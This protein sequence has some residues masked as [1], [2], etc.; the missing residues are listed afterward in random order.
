MIK[1]VALILTILLTFSACKNNYEYVEIVETREGK[2]AKNIKTIHALNDSTAYIE[3]FTRFCISVKHAHDFNYSEKPVYFK[4]YNNK[5]VDISD[6]KFSTKNSIEIG[7]LK[8][9][10]DLYTPTTGDE[11]ETD[12]RPID[13]VKVKKMEKSFNIKLDEFS[14][15]NTKWY[16]TK[17]APKYSNANGIYCY[18][19]TENG[20]PGNFRFRVQY[21]DDD[22]LFFTHIQF[23]IDGK[24]Y[25]YV[26]NST[27]TDSGNGGYIWEWFDESVKNSDK[28]LINALANAKSAK[29]KFV[30]RK[31]YDVKTITSGQ[32]K[33]INETIELYKALGGKF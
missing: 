12:V 26:P 22:W 31:Y 6:I 11:P 30:G 3:A 25:E 14:N 15:D 18:F 29:I 33:A 8:S 21:Y 7:I 32:I 28:E 5:R 23:S 20:V 24:A 19:Q 17:S 10:T 4:L 13:T 2:S 27:N 9:L 1:Q 16:T